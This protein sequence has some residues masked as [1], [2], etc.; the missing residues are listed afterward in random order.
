MN[1]S[2]P[3]PFLIFFL[4][5]L[6]RPPFGCY[7]SG[8]IST[9]YWSTNREVS[10]HQIH[11]TYVRLLPMRHWALRR[12]TVRRSTILPTILPAVRRPP[13]WRPAV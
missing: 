4:C 3:P 9:H 6:E 8:N 11:T 1:M 10:E 7:K 12:S 5:F 2:A 13:M